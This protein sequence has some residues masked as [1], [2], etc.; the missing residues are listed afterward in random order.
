MRKPVIIPALTVT[1][2]LCAAP[3]ADALDIFGWK[4][5]GSKN[6]VKTAAPAANESGAEQELRRGEAQEADGKLDSALKV[7]RAIVKSEPLT[8]AAAKAQ[9]HVGHILERKG[10]TQAAFKAYTEYTTKYPNGTD[11]DGVIKAQFDI[12]KLYLGGKKSK[13][14]GVSVQLKS[15]YEDAEKMFA[16]IVKRAPYHRLAPLA[17]FN[18]GLAL[19][20]Q[21][22]V[23][24][25][26]AA[27]KDLITRFPGDPVAHDAQYQ[28]GYVQLH[29]AQTGSYNQQTR[30]QAVES[31]EEYMNRQ[32]KSEKTAQAR[33]N[34][35]ALTAA[36]IK[37]T[38]D[39]AK[40]YDKTKNY[41]AA[42][43]YYNEVIRNAPGG[44]ES[45]HARKRIEELKGIAGADVL[46]TAPEK[47]QTGDMALARRRAQAR[48]DVASRPDFNGPYIPL[49]SLP[50]DGRPNIRTPL[51]PM[52]PVTEP[53]LPALDPL[54]DPSLP[55]LRT[56]DPLIPL[57]PLPP[58]APDPGKPDAEP[59][60]KAQ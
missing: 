46:R 49:P 51:A 6:A 26:V 16:E 57:A 59:P 20:K 37:S 60:K 2:I 10:D 38:M 12:G 40:F 30:Q 8:T 50:D 7:F 9:Y 13:V 23:A 44:K 21:T 36:E 18:Y 56:G 22:K 27:Y 29:E 58:P 54:Q 32:P 3:M 15:P 28:I 11:F 35:K 48:V 41:R 4:P 47:A 19:E 25:A 39:I 5:F 53:P 52:G 34:V 43:V 14:M 33:E 1:A 45:D 17:Q 42:A 31:F 24:E 55:K